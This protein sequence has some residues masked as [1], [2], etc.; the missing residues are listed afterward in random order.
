MENIFKYDDMIIYEYIK[1]LEYI[2]DKKYYKMNK[3]SKK[4]IFDLNDLEI[5]EL[6][7]YRL[8][9]NILPKF[10]N[11]ILNSNNDE[12][13]NEVEDFIDKNKIE[14]IMEQSIEAKDK[15][16]ATSLIEESKKLS[17]KDLAKFIL[18]Y[19]SKYNTLSLA[20]SYAFHFI[21]SMY[22]LESIRNTNNSIFDSVDVGTI[23]TD[24]EDIED[25]NVD[26]RIYCI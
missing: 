20:K 26:K 10:Y 22:I 11:Y 16:Y 18:E 7:N 19:K 6:Q 3:L 25:E 9:L 1:W 14:D 2:K 12:I 5:E 23:I 17:F 15:E 13:I 8:I 21:Y 4:S 24:Y